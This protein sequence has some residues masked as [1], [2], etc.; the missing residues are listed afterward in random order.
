MKPRG[1]V[2]VAADVASLG[3]ISKINDS[4]EC[5][6]QPGPGSRDDSIEGLMGTSSWNSV[7]FL[8]ELWELLKEHPGGRI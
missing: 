7:V 5:F 8:S 1:V 4:L 6:P 3:Y 2:T